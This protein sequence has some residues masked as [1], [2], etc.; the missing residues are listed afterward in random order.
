MLLKNNNNLLPLNPKQHIGI[1]GDAANKISSQ[2]GGWTI[3]W[4]GRENSNDDFVNV[5]SIYEA[6]E[7]LIASSGGTVEFSSNGKFS[8]HLMLLLVFLAKNHMLKC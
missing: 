5:N 1:I 2:T 4:Q 8:K 7:K 3:T 6:L